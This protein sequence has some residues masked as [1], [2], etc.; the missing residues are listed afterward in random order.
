MGWA[1]NLTPSCKYQDTRMW[2][3][4]D[5][6]RRADPKGEASV[7]CT[8]CSA[9]AGRRLGPKLLNRCS[10]LKRQTHDLDH[11]DTGRRL[12]QLK[13]LCVTLRS[14]SAR[15]IMSNCIEDGRSGGWWVGGGGGSGGGGGGEG[16]SGARRS[17]IVQ[18]KPGKPTQA[19]TIVEP[20]LLKAPV[21][22]C[23]RPTPEI[24][25]SHEDDDRH[26]AEA[27]SHRTFQVHAL[28]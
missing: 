21:K 9:Y 14:P 22:S 19:R 2:A 20:A 4:P 26:D 7:W 5:M 18:K 15:A 12:R 3:R 27:A 6:V 28:N 23:G 10:P 11:V 1:W 16:G 25:G 17:T 13:E 8:N 24:N